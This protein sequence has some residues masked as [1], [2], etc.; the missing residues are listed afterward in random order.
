MERITVLF[1]GRV[2]GVGFRASVRY[3]ARGYDV[4]G[5]VRNL[6]DGGVEM[7]AEGTKAE[8]EAFVQA[9]ATGELSGN[10]ATRPET[11]GKGQGRFHGFAIG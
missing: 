1:T 5:V 6:A 2:Q 7:V 9:I 8:L 11:W 10:I 4:T 3:T